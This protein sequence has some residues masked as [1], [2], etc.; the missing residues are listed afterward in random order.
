VPALA[1]DGTPPATRH[2]RAA[3]SGDAVSPACAPA[4]QRGAPAE[5]DLTRTVAVVVLTALMLLSVAAA[6]AGARDGTGR[7]RAGA[8]SG[9]LIDLSRSFHRADGSARVLRKVR[10]DAPAGSKVAVD[11]RVVFRRSNG[12]T[13]VSAIVDCDGE[14]FWSS[15]NL[16]RGQRQAVIRVRDVHTSTGG[17][18]CLLRVWSAVP[19]PP[20]AVNPQHTFRVDEKRT[21]LRVRGAPDWAAT[22]HLQQ[23][24]V[25]HRYTFHGQPIMLPPNV[26]KVRYVADLE[27]TNC[28]S[29]SGG[30]LVR[31]NL[32]SATFTVQQVLIQRDG[33]GRACRTVIGRVR[34]YRIDREVH[35]RKVYNAMSVRLD[36]ACRGPVV[37]GLRVARVRGNPVMIEDGRWTSIFLTR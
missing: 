21:Y 25:A 28:Y 32:R 13:L 33:R 4:R 11:A 5:A 2:A 6:P 31:Q 7:E 14:V 35:Y 26:R 27:A 23:R 17:G 30:C 29:P 15:Q 18:S 16:R 22:H 1:T 20:G 9:T 36:P 24:R 37:L 34:R 10:F 12:R 8:P 3:P 19:G